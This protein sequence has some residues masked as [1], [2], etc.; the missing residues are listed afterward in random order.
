MAKSTKSAS[1]EPS[2]LNTASWD[3]LKKYINNPSPVGFEA[4]G[5][6]LWL[7]YLKPNVDSHFADPYGTAVGIVNP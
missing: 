4:S 6:K 7:E 5:Q 2:L 3:F 1:S